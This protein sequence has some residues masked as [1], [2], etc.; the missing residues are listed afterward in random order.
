MVQHQV[1][2]QLLVCRIWEYFYEKLN[3]YLLY[4][5]DHSLSSP[6]GYFLY[7]DS[8]G[9]S[10]GDD[11]LL[12]SPSYKGSQPRCLSIWYRLNGASQGS[13]QIQQKPEVDRAKT[14]WTKSNDQGKIFQLS[15]FLF[16]YKCI[17]IF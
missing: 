5:L 17:F 15:L 3:F 1:E 2:H 4:I 13:L 14:I 12:S 16:N 8:T 11:A 9:R 7:I 6:M 10:Q